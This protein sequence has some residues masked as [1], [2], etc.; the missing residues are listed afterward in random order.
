[1]SSD[2]GEFSRGNPGERRSIG[3]IRLCRGYG[4]QDAR[5]YN[6]E[7]ELCRTNRRETRR[8]DCPPKRSCSP[9][10]FSE[11]ERIEV[12]GFRHR[13]STQTN[14]HPALSLEKGEATK[15]HVLS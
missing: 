11:G 13:V 4:G 8:I 15:A 7:E 3:V 12:R 9:L 10:P 1:R 5:G 6:G 14:P 2:L